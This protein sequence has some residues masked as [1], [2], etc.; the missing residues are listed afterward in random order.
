MEKLIT[1]LKSLK[2]YRTKN[3]DYVKGFNKAKAVMLK[4]LNEMK[5]E[6]DKR[7]KATRIKHTDEI[8]KFLTEEKTEEFINMLSDT[9]NF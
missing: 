1:L 4:A 3:I 6:R 5:S 2:P 9:D 8:S 7:R